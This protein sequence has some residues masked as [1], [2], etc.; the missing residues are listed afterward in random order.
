MG[1]LLGDRA[2]ARLSL[3][4]GG[5]ALRKYLW[6][7]SRTPTLSAEDRR[8]IDALLRERGYDPALPVPP[9]RRI[10]AKWRASSASPTRKAASARRPPRST[11]PR[12]GGARASACCWSTSIRRATPR[13]A[14]AS[15]S[16]CWTA[17]GVPGAAR[18]EPTWPTCAAAFREWRLRRVAAPTANW[19]APRSNWSSSSDRE[20]RLK[21]A[22]AA[23]DGEYDFILI[24]C[25]PALTLLTLNGLCA[26]HGVI[27]PMQCEYYALEGLVGPGEHD[28]EGRTPISIRDLKI[29]GLLRVMF[30]PRNTLPQ[31]VSPAARAAFRRQ[32]VRDHDPAQRAAGR[33]AELRLPARSSTALPKERR[34]ISPSAPR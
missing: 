8:A 17:I 10:P 23:V 31:Q 18:A 26:A 11:S 30:D 5:R 22:L 16:E 9:P 34:R 3:R 14:A 27:I 6:V 21:D 2:R 4:R 12:P 13:W 1:R 29:I 7:L 25:P 19:P 32:G 15:T 33:G 20:T 28:Q 24:D